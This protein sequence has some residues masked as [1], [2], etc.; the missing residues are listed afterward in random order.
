MYT[1]KIKHLVMSEFLLGQFLQVAAK[2][3]VNIF[4]MKTKLQRLWNIWFRL[5]NVK[6]I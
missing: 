2:I 6:D 1:A 3:S 4:I 5:L